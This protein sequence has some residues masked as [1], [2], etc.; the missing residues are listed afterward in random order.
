MGRKRSSPTRADYVRRQAGMAG[1]RPGVPN[2]VLVNLRV[3][4]L[5]IPEGERSAAVVAFLA[6]TS[7]LG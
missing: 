3:E 6:A 5:A 2:N 1:V 7:H 4:L